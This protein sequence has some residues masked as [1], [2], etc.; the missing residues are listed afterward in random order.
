MLIE[1]LNYYIPD[2]VCRSVVSYTGFKNNEKVAKIEIYEYYDFNMK[3]YKS[4]PNYNDC[5][6]LQMFSII[7]V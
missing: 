7:M 4:I 5:H 1:A 2:L 3:C 6:D